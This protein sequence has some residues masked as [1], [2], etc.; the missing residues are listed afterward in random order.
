MLR[1]SNDWQQGWPNA[2]G[3]TSGQLVQSR[4]QTTGSHPSH[5]PARHGQGWHLRQPALLSTREL[6]EIIRGRP[7]NLE[8][9][10]ARSDS[11]PGRR[12]SSL[13]PGML[14]DPRRSRQRRTGVMTQIRYRRPAC[15]PNAGRKVA[16]PRFFQ[17][18]EYRELGGREQTGVAGGSP[19]TWSGARLCLPGRQDLIEARTKR[20]G[21]A[22]ARVGAM[23]RLPP[24]LVPGPGVRLALPWRR[25]SGLNAPPGLFR[26]IP[27]SVSRATPAAERRCVSTHVVGTRSI[28]RAAPH[29]WWQ[30][31]A[32]V[33]S[34]GPHKLP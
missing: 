23:R 1:W 16:V 28:E 27:S 17:F 34:A 32:P 11:S 26:R 8:P 10:G 22:R 24:F 15:H 9:L 4:W 25:E 12:G 20:P 14:R 19:S 29:G 13:A 21:S 3:K 2:A 7:G 6:A 18:S 30:G 33:G 31:G 5:H